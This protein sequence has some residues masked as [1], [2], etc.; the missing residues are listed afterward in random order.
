MKNLST[1]VDEDVRNEINRLSVI[2]WDHFR[3]YEL[4]EAELISN[5]IEELAKQNNYSKGYHV[6]YYLKGLIKSSMNRLDLAL[7]DYFVALKAVIHTDDDIFKGMAYENVGRCYGKLGDFKRAI[8]Y[9]QVSLEYNETASIHNNLGECFGKLKEYDSALKH[10]KEAYNLI[11]SNL[12]ENHNQRFIFSDICLNLARVYNSMNYAVKALEYL[13]EIE[14]AIEFENHVVISCQRLTLMGIAYSKLEQFDAAEKYHIESIR[15]AENVDN[16]E[17]LYEAYRNYAEFLATQE[18]FE[19]AVEHN[20]KYLEIRG[21]LFSEEKTNA[22][23]VLQEKYEKE[24]QT[25]IDQQMKLRRQK[26]EV[27]TK[28]SKLKAIFAS[29]T[30]IGQIGIFSSKMKNIIKMVDFFHSD[31]SVPVLIEGE[32]GTGKE[33]IARMIHYNQNENSRPFVIINCSAISA[34]LFESELFGYE[35]GTFTGANKHGRMGKFEAAQ[36]GTIFLDEIG[37]LPLHLQP[38]LLRALQQKE[39]YRVGGHNPISLDVRVIAATNL[40]LQEQ[41][42]LG[43]FRQDLYF[44]LNTGSIYIPPLR[45]RREEIIPLSQMFM[46]SFSKSKRKLFRVISQEAA[47]ILSSHHWP[48]NVRE[49]RNT[50]ER[51]VLLNNDT[52]LQPVHLGFLKTESQKTNQIVVD[53]EKEKHPILEIEK[54]IIENYLLRFD[55]NIKKTADFL[56]T[57]R[58]RIYNAKQ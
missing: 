3:K 35:G 18:R 20:E 24:I 55:N 17:S 48:G 9:F 54:L 31:R 28:F 12:E 45:E 56:Q 46:L 14:R 15:I 11:N 33:I 42:K 50:I 5:Q 10:L 23:S 38:K 51:I 25:I 26:Q 58:N 21:S 16:K 4:H 37:D 34:N 47:E 49:L 8:K 43:K 52:A 53:Y 29:V 36:G 2:G 32:T 13:K 7:K 30:G 44:R 6:A 40:D 1:V 39:I 22:I 27:D 41:V 57:S 19:E